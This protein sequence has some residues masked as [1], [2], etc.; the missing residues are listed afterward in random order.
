LLTNAVYWSRIETIKYRGQEV[1]GRDTGSG[2][3]VIIERQL[4]MSKAHPLGCGHMC[5]TVL[6]PSYMDASMLSGGARA[7]HNTFMS[8][9]VDHGIPGAAFY[10][11]MLLWIL[12][13]V[14]LLAARL[15]DDDDFL[16]TVFPAV[17]GVLGAITVGDMFVQYMKFEAR[18]WFLGLLM[19]LLHFS[20][21]R[22]RTG[23]D[24]SR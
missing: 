2:R 1:E 16:A 22:V 17:A 21:D 9:L 5:T 3:L 12:R 4:Q 8:M 18:F 23:P 24:V 19:V 13:S 10:L 15:K 11:A 20:G 7:S 14:R 6:S